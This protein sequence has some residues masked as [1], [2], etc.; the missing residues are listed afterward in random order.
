[1]AAARTNK[2]T[3]NVVVGKKGIAM[4]HVDAVDSTPYRQNIGLNGLTGSRVAFER[5]E[6]R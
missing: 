4:L 2:F 1:M 3:K 5:D 6:R